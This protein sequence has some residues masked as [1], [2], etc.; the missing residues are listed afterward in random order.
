MALYV[1]FFRGH[2]VRV[3]VLLVLVYYYLFWFL[4]LYCHASYLRLGYQKLMVNYMVIICLF[5]I[6][7][8]HCHTCTITSENC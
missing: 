3:Q 7:L 6:I 8:V 2:V 4:L 1:F 5:V